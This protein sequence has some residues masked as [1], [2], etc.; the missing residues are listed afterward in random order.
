M[1]DAIAVKN[2]S[3]VSRTARAL[4]DLSLAVSAGDPLGSEDE[5]LARLGV[6]RPTLRQAAKMVES[7]RMI[8]VRRGA[9]GG[10][11]AARPHAADVI[12]APARYLRLN[13]A[14][15]ADVH[16]VTAAI[17]ETTAAAA[18]RS[19]NQDLRAQLGVFRQGIDA[20]DTVGD[21]IRAESELARLLAEMGGNPVARLFLEISHTFGRNEHQLRFYQ[22]AED[23]H[24]ARGLQH[25]LCDAVLAGDPDIA[26]LMMQRRSALIAE[27]LARPDTHSRPETQP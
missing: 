26:R 5:L 13:G 20:N 14:T 12:R 16:A 27:W 15:I 22:S 7:D 23:R 9:K 11:Y 4:A 2:G 8:A 19:Q 10:F 24:R 3:L 1:P 17:S 18:A 21:I 25:R 6:S